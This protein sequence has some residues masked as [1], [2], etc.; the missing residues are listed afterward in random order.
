MSYFSIV[1]VSECPVLFQTSESDFDDYYIAVT[2]TLAFLGHFF[3]VYLFVINCTRIKQK[4]KNVQHRISI[5]Q[6]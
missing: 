5:L 3:E 2:V 6:Y 4:I 1:I